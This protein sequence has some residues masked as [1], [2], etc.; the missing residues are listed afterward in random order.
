MSNKAINFIFGSSVCSFCLQSFVSRKTAVGRHLDSLGGPW[1]MNCGIPHIVSQCKGWNACCLLLSSLSVRHSLPFDVKKT[2]SLCFPTWPQTGLL[3][4][5]KPKHHHQEGHPECLSQQLQR[6]HL[7]FTNTMSKFTPTKSCYPVYYFK[8]TEIISRI[9]YKYPWKK[10]LLFVCVCV[11]WFLSQIVKNSSILL[12]VPLQCVIKGTF[13]PTLYNVAAV[14][15]D[16]PPL[17]TRHFGL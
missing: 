10:S 17:P 15:N 1:S 14:F 13:K 5:R 8:G 6:V 2:Q 7:T 11:C 4:W 9:L 12:K 3:F 16:S